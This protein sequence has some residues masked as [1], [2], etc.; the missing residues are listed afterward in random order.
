MKN[1]NKQKRKRNTEKERREG[2]R[3]DF[4]GYEVIYTLIIS[5]SFYFFVRRIS[6]IIKLC[7]KPVSIFSPFPFFAL[8]LFG[9]SYNSSQNLLIMGVA[10]SLISSFASNLWNHSNDIKEDTLQGKKTVLT[11]KFISYKT[12]TIISMLLYGISMILISYLSITLGKPIFIF[13]SIWLL[14]TWL[15][16][17]NIFIGK[18]F[19]FRLKT[20]YIGEIVTYGIAYPTYTL[21]IWL[22]YSDLNISGITVA[23]VF[24]FLG[25]SGVMIKD[26]KDISGDRK[27]GLRTLG[28]KFNP[29]ELLFISCIFI[30]L[31]YIT[32]LYS[33][34]FRI[35]KINL[36]I[37]F[38]IL[39]FVWFLQNTFYHFHKKGWRLEAND[40]GSIQ[41]MN[42]SI[43]ISLIVL[44]IG[45]FI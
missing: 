5:S 32:I 15:Y 23:L 33:I 38:V 3:R 42:A 34:F 19:G 45:A 21:S 6:G 2:S 9:I 30:I 7:C 35:L 44:G 14:I 29:S 17:D 22:I 18:I 11:Q 20:H 28:V 37:L 1:E 26:L 43:Y 4:Q 12:T 16:S 24:M 25:L 41:V 10:V 27:A 31:Y 13:F 40:I 39:P 36:S 8:M